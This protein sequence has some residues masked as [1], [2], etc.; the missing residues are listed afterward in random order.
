MS[1]ETAARLLQDFLHSL[2]SNGI[3]V[4]VYMNG[5]LCVADLTCGDWPEIEVWGVDGA[6]TIEP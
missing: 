3:R 5:T 6:I 4:E 2:E 1:P